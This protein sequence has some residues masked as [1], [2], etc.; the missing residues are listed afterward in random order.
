MVTNI[1]QSGGA[2]GIGH[3]QPFLIDTLIEPEP[4]KD[5]LSSSHILIHLIYQ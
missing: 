1:V 2:R 4:E 3:G 5:K